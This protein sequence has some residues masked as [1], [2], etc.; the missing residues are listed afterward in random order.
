MA[1]GSSLVPDASFIMSDTAR[2]SSERSLRVS[3][4]AAM[5]E[6]RVIGQ[7]GRLPWHLPA[8]LRRF[9]TLTTEHVLIMGRKTFESLGR[10]LSRRTSIVLT[11][12]QDYRPRGV[13]VAHDF[14]SALGM[15]ARDPVSLTPRGS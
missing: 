6:N 11:R 5:A 8:D 9:R 12:R 10:P 7:E 1:H 3:I 13:L 4:V 2:P 14:E 15:A